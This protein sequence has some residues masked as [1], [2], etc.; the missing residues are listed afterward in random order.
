VN[1]RQNDYDLSTPQRY[2]RVKVGFKNDGAVTAVQ[3]TA[4]GDSG[5]RVTP[6][7]L[8]SDLRL[9]PFYTTRCQNLKTDY[10]GVFTNTGRMYTTGQMFPYNFDEL[11]MAEQMIAERLGMDPIDVAFKNIHGPA[12]QVDP[13]IPPSFRLCVEEGKKAMNWQWHP[14]GSRKLSDGRMHGLSFRYQMSPRHGTETYSC[15]V[16]IQG[17]GKVYMPLKGPWCGVYSQTLARWWL[18]KNLEPG[19]KTSSSF[20]IQRRSSH[21]WGWAATARPRLPGLQR[22]RRWLAEIASGDRCPEVQSKAGSLDTGDS[23]VFLKA[24]RGRSF[25]F[26]A[27]PESGDHDKD[28]AATF[29]GR[30]P[31][32]TWNIAQ[33]RI[34]DTMNASFCEVAVDTETGLVEVIKYVVVC[35]PGKVLRPTSLESQIH[36]VMMFS[37]GAGL[38]EEFIFDKATGVK[39]HTNMIEYKKPTILDI[40]PVETILGNAV[41][42]CRL[43][44]LRHQPRDGDPAAY[45][46]R[47]GQRYGQVDCSAADARQGSQSSWQGVVQ[48]G[49]ALFGSC[50]AYHG[51][52]RAECAPLLPTLSADSYI[53]GG[54]SMSEMSTPV[55]ANHFR[56]LAERTTREDDFL[57]KLKAAAR[58]ENIPPIW[59]SPEQ[60]SFMQI[61]LKAARVREVI[62]VGTLAGYSAIWMARALPAGGHVR[63]IEISSQ[64]AD[65]AERWISKSDVAGRIQVHRGRGEEILP[66]FATDSAD[67]AFIDADKSG[68]PLFLRESLRIVRRGGLILADNAFGFGR[69]FDM[70]DPGVAAMRAFNDIMA[71]E[72]AHQSIIVPVGDG[73]WFGLKL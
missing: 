36:Q 53:R 70:D 12:S 66:Q 62:E 29:T 13:G 20:M 24:D 4:V 26:S 73:L 60:G 30:P 47:S 72:A 50:S 65:F 22:K 63:T 28:I 14:A 44:S 18:Q 67:A 5:V 39:L 9:N 1:S 10:Q 54:K 48:S 3:E 34:L 61:L 8:S 6:P 16:T 68:Y 2:T 23:T 56:Y 21:L 71:K 55:T 7:Y 49:P 38:M 33:G 15:T 32:A 64:H 41:R 51:N 69:L 58:A 46:L 25:P 52:F 59:I 43:W 31:T 57:R 40:G 19:L 37:D 42:Q 11:T 17:D 35:D 45:C 27:F